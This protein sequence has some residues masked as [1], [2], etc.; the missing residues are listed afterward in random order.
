[1]LALP[2]RRQHARF[3]LGT[4]LLQELV[5]ER[6]AH[7]ITVHPPRVFYPLPPE[8][9]HHWFRVPAGAALEHVVSGDTRVVH[10]YASVENRALCERIDPRY[11]RLQKDQQLFSALVAP[12][13]A[14]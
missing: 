1:M 3:A 7:E 2:R 10:W 6:G 9:S 11:V 12:F 14:S 5:A 8:I 13:V 4:H